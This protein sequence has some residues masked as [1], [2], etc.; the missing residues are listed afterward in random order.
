LQRQAITASRGRL[1]ARAGNRAAGPVSGNG[2][3]TGN[4]P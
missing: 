1:L 2:G 4:D 3:E